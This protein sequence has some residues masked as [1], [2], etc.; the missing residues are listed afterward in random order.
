M[1][2]WCSRLGVWHRANNPV[3]LKK[4]H[5]VT[6]TAAKD[7]TTTVCRGLSESPQITRMNGSGEIC[8]EATDRIMK[9][10]GTKTKTRIGFW[11]VQTLYQTAEMR[12]YCL[13][14]LGVSESRWTGSGNESITKTALHWTPEGRRKRGRPKNTWRRTVETEL[15][16]LKQSWNKIQQLAKDRQ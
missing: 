3:L 7:T 11:N 12:C 10:L 8:K 1:I 9:V 6:E 2:F 16:G 4:N 15:R 14:I 13:H 5:Y